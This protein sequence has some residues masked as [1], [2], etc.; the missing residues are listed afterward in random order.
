VT[1]TTKPRDASV[2]ACVRRAVTR[3]SFP[4]N[5]RLD[6]TRTRFDALR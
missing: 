5:P 2:S 3:L 4:T 1:V 6:V